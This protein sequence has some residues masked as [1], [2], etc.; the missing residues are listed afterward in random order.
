MKAMVLSA[1]KTPLEWQDVPKPT[2]DAREVLLR[3]RA[4][5]AGLTLH[6]IVSGSRAAKLPVIIG[7]EV[8]GEVI[9]LGPE[10]QGVAIGETVT[11]HAALFCGLCRMCRTSRE[12]LCEAMAGAGIGRQIDGGYAEYMVVP[13]RNCIRVPQAVI[14]RH[15]V[16]GA[17]I[18][19]DAMVTP[20]KTLRHTSLRAGEVCAIFGAAGGVGIHLIQMA[21]LR[22]AHVIG[23]DIAADKLAAMSAQ[24][25]DQVLDAREHDVAREVRR[26]T[27]GW[28]AD[29]V[30]DFVGTSD[31]LKHGVD[32]L[33]MNGRLSIIGLSTTSE[34]LVTAKAAPLLYGER[35]IIGSR[36]F[37]RQEVAECIALVANGTYHPVVNHLFPLEKANEA[38]TLVASGRSIGRVV[39]T[40]D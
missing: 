8:L 37:S 3:V 7:H 9:A 1:I 18:I 30:A 40:M 4:C 12:P 26:I 20:Y 34:A 10:A 39:L 16:T 23:I 29:V 36:G 17:C 35:S 19:C 22:G 21:K 15:G 38:H 33:A 2:P 25:A 11:L 6:H 24:G 32:M 5:G 14:D 13:D 31:T 27:N 28:G